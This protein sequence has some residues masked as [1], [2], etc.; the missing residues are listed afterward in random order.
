LEAICLC[1]DSSS[2]LVNSCIYIDTIFTSVRHDIYWFCLVLEALLLIFQ[3]KYRN[4]LKLLPFSGIAC[5]YCYVTSLVTLFKPKVWWMHGW[6]VGE[7]I[8]IFIVE[9]FENSHPIYKCS[10][11]W[12]M[13]FWILPQNMLEA[14]FKFPNSYCLKCH[15]KAILKCL[16]FMAFLCIL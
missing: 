10:R 8:Y 7:H 2:L 13:I 3:L 14:I 4:I 16:L 11:W 15:S 12:F 5:Y 1:Y 6:E 9:L